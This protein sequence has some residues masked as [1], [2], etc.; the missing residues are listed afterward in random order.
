[1]RVTTKLPVAPTTALPTTLPSAARTL[2]VAPASPLPVKTVPATLSC[3]PVT[4]P[5]AVTSS[6]GSAPGAETLPAAS[7]RVTCKVVPVSCAVAKVIWK[8]PSAATVPVPTVAPKASRT[9]MLAP[10]SPRP[11]RTVPAA[12]RLRAEGTAGAVKSGA[13]TLTPAEMLPP[14]SVCV[15]V[16]TCWSISAGTN[17]TLKV[18]SVPTVPVPTSWPWASRTLTVAPASP[19]PL[20]VLPLALSTTLAR[21]SGAVSSRAVSRVG[22]DTRAPSLA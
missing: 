9:R 22:T 12:L 18:P 20:R 11:F 6:T 4:T 15:A 17:V 14:A 10:A 13:V 16:R 19:V 8:V 7:V 1:M 3:K 5:G 2:T 21:V